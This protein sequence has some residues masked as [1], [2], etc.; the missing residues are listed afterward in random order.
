MHACMQLNYAIGIFLHS[1][2]PQQNCTAYIIICSLKYTFSW[3]PPV[4]IIIHADCY[5]Y[6]NIGKF[7]QKK[8]G[9]LH[10]CQNDFMQSIIIFMINWE[11]DQAQR[12]R[13]LRLY[14]VDH[15]WLLWTDLVSHK[16]LLL[17]TVCSQTPGNPSPNDTASTNAVACVATGVLN[18]Q[19]LRTCSTMLAVS[20]P[21]I[22]I[23]H[24]AK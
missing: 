18:N 22:S 15:A 7:H 11:H 17:Y 23:Q 4:T 21:I 10:A 20:S 5:I 2:S 3:P 13:V 16:P 1:L 9:S 14:T 6:I 12:E 8:S 24:I 19:N